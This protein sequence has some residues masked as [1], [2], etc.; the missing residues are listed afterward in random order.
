MS[1]TQ[2]FDISAISVDVERPTAF[3]LL[4]QQRQGLSWPNK[5]ESEYAGMDLE[6]VE[7]LLSSDEPVILTTD[8]AATQWDHLEPLPEI[9]VSVDDTRDDR[10]SQDQ[11]DSSEQDG[12]SW[13][14]VGLVVAIVAIVSLAVWT[15]I[16]MD[17]TI[18]SLSRSIDELHQRSANPVSSVVVSDQIDETVDMILEEVAES[19]IVEEESVS[20]ATPYSFEGG[21]TPLSRSDFNYESFQAHASL[22]P[23]NTELT[24]PAN[25]PRV[26]PSVGLRHADLAVAQHSEPLKEIAKR[27]TNLI[28][29][30]G[31]ISAISSSTRTPISLD[32]QASFALVTIPVVAKSTEVAVSVTREPKQPIG[33]ALLWKES[34]FQATETAERESKLVFV[35]HV[36]N[37]FQ[38]RHN[39]SNG[40]T[41][42]TTDA[43]SS[44]N[45][46][47]YFSKHFVSTYERIDHW[48][49]DKEAGDKDVVADVVGYFCTPNGNVIHSVV[50]GPSA[51]R[52]LQEAKWAVETFRSV[53]DQDAEM[54]KQQVATAHIKR[55]PK[56]SGWTSL[57]NRSTEQ[58]GG[59][60]MQEVHRLFADHP[61]S[62]LPSVYRTISEQILGRPVAEG[63]ISNL[64]LQ[65]GH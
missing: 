10:S 45:I 58:E 29:H 47:E 60:Q 62:P 8:Q 24:T 57:L 56:K 11:M 55:M 21:A 41:A 13:G 51:E 23:L 38:S 48:S 40:V 46:G 59:K 25:A 16:E 32:L 52:F 37:D 64:A 9:R 18:A 36:A 28:L 50:G 17:E 53:K 43:L 5:S 65:M 14:R 12:I 20:V 7:S 39:T 19:S 4:P 15:R 61:M 3:N 30:D 42:F 1:R 26:M 49:V 6:E 54:R 2:S 27:T 31:E 33:T 63:D 22:L 35:L 34:V 44:A